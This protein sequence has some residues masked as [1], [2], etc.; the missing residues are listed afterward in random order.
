[1]IKSDHPKVPTANEVL[2]EKLKPTGAEVY[3]RLLEN[4][5]ASTR[6]AAITRNLNSWSK[7]RTWADKMRRDWRS[8]TKKGS[9]SSGE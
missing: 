3:A 7:Y 9:S 5:R 6:H 8:D 1:M 2:A 4:M